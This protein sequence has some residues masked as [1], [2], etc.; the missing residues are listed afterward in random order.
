MKN[1]TSFT[2]CSSKIKVDKPIK[3]TCKKKES[4]ALSFFLKRKMDQKT[5]GDWGEGGSGNLTMLVFDHLK[6]R[7][8]SW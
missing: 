6:N 3:T 1:I 5:H 8:N 7:K 4:A 2:L